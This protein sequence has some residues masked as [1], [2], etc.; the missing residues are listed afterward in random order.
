MAPRPHNSGHWTMDSGGC[1]QFEMLVRAAAGLPLQA[2]TRTADVTMINLVGE[3]VENLS[4]YHADPNARIHL[5]GK[6]EARAGRKMGHVNVVK[7]RKS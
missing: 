1:D 3:D 6:A 2:P 7:P 5:Y 4:K